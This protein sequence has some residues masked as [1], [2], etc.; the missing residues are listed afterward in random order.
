MARILLLLFIS[1]YSISGL[2]QDKFTLNGY[3]RDSVSGESL[4]GANLSI[5]SEGKGVSSN[6]YGFYS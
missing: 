1:C 4:I 6:Q 5:R 3:I 2:A